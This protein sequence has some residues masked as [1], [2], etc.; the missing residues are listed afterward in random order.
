MPEPAAFPKTDPEGETYYRIFWQ[1]YDEEGG[2]S[3]VSRT[4]H[5][6]QDGWCLTLPEKWDDTVTVSRQGTVDSNSVSF[7]ICSG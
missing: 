6:M 4:L 3:T 1:Q 2:C 5:N 7:F